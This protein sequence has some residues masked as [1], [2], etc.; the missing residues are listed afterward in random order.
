MQGHLTMSQKERKYLSWIRQVDAGQT[1][2]ETAAQR[3]DVS[4]RHIYRLLNRY[5]EEGEEGLLHRSRGKPSNHGYGQKIK[6]QIKELY[7]EKYADYGPTLFSEQLKEHH[8]TSIDHETLRRWLMGLYPVCRKERPHRKKRARRAGYGELLQLDG[9][10]HN[11]FE[12]RR[13][14]CC[15]LVAV[16][17]A[18]SQSFMRFCESENEW[19]IMTFLRDYCLRFGRPWSLYVDRTKTIYSEGEPTAIA[20]A[21]KQVDIEIIFA[22]SPQAKGRVERHNRTLQDRLVKALRRLQIASIKE[23]N[24]YLEKTFMNEY[25]ALFASREPISN[26]HRSLNGYDVDLIFS[27]PF[28]RQVRSDYTLLFQNQFI[29]LLTGKAPLPK[30]RQTATIRRYLDHSLHVFYNDQELHFERFQKKKIANTKNSHDKKL[31]LYRKKN[32]SLIDFAFH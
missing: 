30:P 19:D 31:N 14:A 22:R 11:W 18:G 26:V 17:D 1:T 29:Q 12:G 20:K 24:D 9:S 6:E 21:M 10:H 4:P 5:H 3:C 13:P 15:L 32:P 23:A 16:D 7:Q 27:F 25:N 8:Q 2:V 28:D